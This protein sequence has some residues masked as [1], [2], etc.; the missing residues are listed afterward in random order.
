MQMRKMIKLAIIPAAGK[1]TRLRPLTTAIPKEMLHV[2]GKPVIEYVIENVR[3]AGIE[4]VIVVTGYQK[5]AILDYLGSGSKL[6][7]KIAYAVQDE[8]SGLAHAVYSARHIVKDN[9]FLVMLGDNILRPKSFVKDLIN[10]HIK[11]K[12][13]A[14]IGVLEVEDVSRYG[15]VKINP[16]GKVLDLVEKPNPEQ[17]PSN[18]AIAGIYVFEPI[19]FNAI[20]KTKP[21]AKNEYQLTDSIKILLQEGYPVY[22]LKLNGIHIDCGTIE[23]LV[24]ANEILMNNEE[25]K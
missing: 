21:G 2:A 9:S 3:D 8:L 7:V 15:I 12:S 16:E 19:I 17:A 20:E 11:S 22:A 5:H 25:F 23:D 24:K 1:G 18:L 4:D 13:T 10:F 6:G 14:T